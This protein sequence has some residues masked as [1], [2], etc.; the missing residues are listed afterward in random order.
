MAKEARKMTELEKIDYL[1]EAIKCMNNA[2]DN[3]APDLA[4]LEIR[5]AAI[6]I[7]R[8]ENASD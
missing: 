6:M 3:S 4:S 8:R 1:V 2:V 5:R 7:E